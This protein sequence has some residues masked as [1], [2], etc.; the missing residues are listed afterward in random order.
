MPQIRISIMDQ[1]GGT[2]TT[3]EVPDDVPMNQLIP[4]LITSLNLPVRQ[5]G[6]LISYRLDNISTNKRL[7]DESTLADAGVE[8]GSIF[9]LSP[10]VTAG[11][12]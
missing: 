8:S 1:I 2:K 7:A 5:A 4:A 11:R 12:S 9:S 3:V 10:E 6:N